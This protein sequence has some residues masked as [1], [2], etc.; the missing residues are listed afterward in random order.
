MFYSHRVRAVPQHQIVVSGPYGLTGHPAYAGMII[1]NIGPS[2]YFFNWVT[3][4]VFLLILSPA[5]I[6]R[7]VIEE[8]MLFKIDGY[9]EFARNRKRLLPGIW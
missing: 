7:I 4:C 8:Q 6:L 9:P 5:I 1:A 3:L 2:V